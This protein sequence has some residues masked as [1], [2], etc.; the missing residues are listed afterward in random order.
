M[1]RQISQMKPDIWAGWTKPHVRGSEGNLHEA[2][3]WARRC[4][5]INRTPAPKAAPGQPPGVSSKKPTPAKGQGKGGKVAIKS[6]PALKA[7]PVP[8]KKM[9]AAKPPADSQ[10]GVGQVGMAAPVSPPRPLGSRAPVTPPKQLSPQRDNKDV[11]PEAKVAK[12]ETPAEPASSSVKPEAAADPVPGSKKRAQ[13]DADQGTPTPADSQVALDSSKAQRPKPS[14]ERRQALLA[15]LRA[16]DE[17]L[18]VDD[19][20]IH[21]CGLANASALTKDGHTIFHRLMEAIRTE[22]LS[23]DFAGRVLDAGPDVF[24]N[25]LSSGGQPSGVAPLHMLCGSGRDHAATRCDV[26]RKLASRMADLEVRDARGATPL[27]RAAGVQAV[28]VV[29]TLLELRA[30]PAA[31]HA[32]TRR[33]AADVGNWQALL[34]FF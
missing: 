4:L 2:M 15:E 17:E 12:V 28:E 7:P 13:D 30:D 9:P 31:T 34:P 32:S 5:E 11:K 25:K 29:K 26:L 16:V 21:G 33:N 8:V 14:L 19:F 24:L 1:L 20:I 18:S 6:T 10:G 22:E 3:D 23:A 27:L